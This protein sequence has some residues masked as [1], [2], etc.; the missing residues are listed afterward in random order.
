M[1]EKLSLIALQPAQLAH[2]LTIN[3]SGVAVI[4]VRDSD[5]Y[6]IAQIAGSI[7]FPSKNSSDL[8]LAALYHDLIV[9]QKKHLVVFHCVSSLGRGPKI[10]KQFLDVV[11]DI[12]RSPEGTAT[13]TSLSIAVLEG[14]IKAFKSWA[15]E[16][17][18][19]E[20]IVQTARS[21]L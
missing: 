20:L 12:V 10:A 18:R 15:T 5:R 2:E 16:N 3:S 14:G 9:R 4:D 13:Q 19:L 11:N 1:P 7:W 21:N 8:S 17:G 6:S